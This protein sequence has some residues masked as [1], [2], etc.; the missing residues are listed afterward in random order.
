MQTNSLIIIKIYKIY[1]IYI[2][3][4]KNQEKNI[5]ENKIDLK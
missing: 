2:Y 3:I 5:K 4:K 1:I